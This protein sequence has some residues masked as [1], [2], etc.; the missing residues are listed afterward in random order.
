MKKSDVKDRFAAVAVRKYVERYALNRGL[1]PAWPNLVV[2][3]YPE[4]MTGRAVVINNDGSPDPIA[5]FTDSIRANRAIND[6][7]DFFDA[8][9]RKTWKGKALAPKTVTIR[10]GRVC[11]T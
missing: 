4:P 1:K 11:K 6:A 2:S 7:R 5:T 9:V 3:L 10:Y 8:L